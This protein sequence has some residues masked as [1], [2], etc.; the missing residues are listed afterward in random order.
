MTVTAVA[1]GIVLSKLS[2]RPSPNLSCER[3]KAISWCKDSLGF[4]GEIL[5][6]KDQGPC[7][8]TKN[9]FG[10]N[11]RIAPQIMTDFQIDRRNGK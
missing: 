9:V 2:V 1:R 8:L 5:V 10:H 6:V 11:S 4:D 3:L 7:D